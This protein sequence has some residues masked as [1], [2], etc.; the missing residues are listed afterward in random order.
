MFV[1]HAIG[2]LRDRECRGCGDAGDAVGRRRHLSPVRG[3]RNH[4]DAQ[5]VDVGIDRHERRTRGRRSLWCRQR[6][7]QMLGAALAI[8]AIERDPHGSP[9]LRTDRRVGP[10]PPLIAQHRP[11][12]DA[13]LTGDRQLRVVE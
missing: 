7:Q 9:L 8:T 12:V 1:G 13:V 2:A 5:R 3:W 6:Q 10:P 11:T 4:R